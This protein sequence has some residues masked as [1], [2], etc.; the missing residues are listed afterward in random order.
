MAE[1]EEYYDYGDYDDEYEESR[2]KYKVYSGN[3]EKFLFLGIDFEDIFF[4]I[5]GFEECEKFTVIDK[6]DGSD[7]SDEVIKFVQDEKGF[8]FKDDVEKKIPAEV[9]Q[10][11][12]VEE[13]CD[14]C[15]YAGKNYL[16]LFRLQRILCSDEGIFFWKN[17]FFLIGNGDDLG[18]YHHS[19]EIY[20]DRFSKNS[21]VYAVKCFSTRWLNNKI[22]RD[23]LLSS[24][25]IL[26]ED[27]QS[28]ANNLIR[29]DNK[30]IYDK[31]RKTPEILERERIEKEKE[32]S[33]ELAIQKEVRGEKLDYTIGNVL[34]NGK[35]F[36]TIT[37]THHNK[38]FVFATV[39]LGVEI[40][41]ENAIGS[42]LEKSIMEFLE[43]D[44]FS[45]MKSYI[46]E[47]PYWNKFTEH[48]DD[49]FVR[50]NTIFYHYTDDKFWQDG[51]EYNMIKFSYDHHL[52]CYML[53]A[54]G[55]SEEELRKI[56][57]ENRCQEILPKDAYEKLHNFLLKEHCLTDEFNHFCSENGIPNIIE[58]H[59]VLRS[60]DFDNYKEY[61]D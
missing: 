9:L 27:F 46:A 29:F 2:R 59:E 24:E 1:Y 28:F 39:N 45:D 4:Q 12:P 10:V 21:P 54:D 25:N 34:F 18:N 5:K 7:V 35:N 48:C 52:F 26:C 36:E 49:N 6:T 56:A 32:A 37:F 43:D 22:T 51:K 58:Q 20:I 33:R 50:I 23:E 17:G 55:M 61:I 8:V 3:R 15:E 14:F 42:D 30:E 13:R 40:A 57:K 53:A 38:K 11:L 16:R 41:K 44:I 19:T 47:E 31:K 60:F